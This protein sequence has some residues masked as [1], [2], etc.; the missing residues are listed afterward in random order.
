V[1]GGDPTQIHHPRRRSGRAAEKDYTT[2]VST[3]VIY[4]NTK[5][6]REYIRQ[7]W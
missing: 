7:R 4:V 3:D 1:C 2:V 5:G 6:R